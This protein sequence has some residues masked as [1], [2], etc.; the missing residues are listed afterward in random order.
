MRTAI[1]LGRWESPA[2]AKA[3]EAAEA[4]T[5]DQYASQWI[6][7]RRSRKGLP[8][9]VRTRREY[10]RLLAGACAEIGSLPLTQITRSI[11][12][13]WYATQLATG[14]ATQAARAYTL[15]RSV[16]ATAVEDGLLNVNPAMVKGGGKA[17]TGRRV[18]PPTNEETQA[19]L[20]AASAGLK[21]L[22][23]I[24]AW[25]GLRFGEIAALRRNDILITRD[26]D[27]GI[28]RL[29]VRVDT[30]IVRTTQDG[31]VEKSPKSEAGERTLAMPPATW[32]TLTAYLDSLPKTPKGYLF[33]AK[34]SGNPISYDSIRA[35]WERLRTEVGRPDLGLHS[36]R[37]YGAT[38]YAQAG[39]TVK[40]L[41]DRLGH[42][43]VDAAMTYQHSMGRDADLAARMT[44]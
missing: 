40:E 31:I 39:A 15:V 10:Q 38:K 2:A 20:A 28:T 7:A 3:R 5:L 21:P 17:R 41:Q 44:E 29:S 33:P 42:A 26:R 23:L 4:L 24:A 27:G 22:L 16:C 12:R 19:I 11:V 25:G 9:A 1:S 34:R 35:E 30:S 18:T 37:H 14:H 6:N 43:T 13:D 8:L 32:E 36:L